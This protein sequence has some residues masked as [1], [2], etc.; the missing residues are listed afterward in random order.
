MH[1]IMLKPQVDFIE[2][3]TKASSQTSAKDE[4]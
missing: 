3:N 1:C 2:W 4:H